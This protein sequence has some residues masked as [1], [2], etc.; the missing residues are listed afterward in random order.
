MFIVD[1]LLPNTIPLLRLN[2]LNKP[3]MH[4]VKF[5]TA[6]EIWMTEESR[7]RRRMRLWERR[8][9]LRGKDK[10]KRLTVS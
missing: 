5:K 8:R 9:S 2:S 3:L 6:R 10:S 1:I 7:S 4:G